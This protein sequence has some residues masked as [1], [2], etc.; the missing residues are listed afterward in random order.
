[1]RI[2]SKLTLSFLAFA[3][4]PLAVG[5]ALALHYQTQALTGQMR[6]QLESVAALQAQRLRELLAQNLERLALV[7]SRTQL[8][9]SLDRYV[10]NGDP[11]QRERL[12]RILRDARASIPS[13]E[14]I[15]VR[16][17]QGRVVAATDESLPGMSQGEEESFPL[18]SETGLGN[19]Y[20]SERGGK[21][22][23]RLAGPL[24]LE[25][26]KIG[27]VIVEGAADTIV[28]L[29]RD[30]TGL[31]DTGETV[32]VG[33]RRDG[34]PV[35]LTPL[36]FAPHAALKPIGR[37]GARTVCEAAL[38]ADGRAVFT[39]GVDYRGR[40]VLAAS[41]K[42]DPP[43]WALVV[44]KDRSEAFVPILKLRASVLVIIALTLVATLVAAPLLARSSTG[45]IRDLTRAAH[46]AVS[47][48]LSGR[49]KVQTHD[50]VGELALAFNNMMQSIESAREGLERKVEQRTTELRARNEDLAREIEER[51]KARREREK[52]L[53]EL[54]RS[55]RDLEQFAYV[56]S[57]DLQEPLR[58]VASFVD[59]LAKKYKGK[60]DGDADQYIGFAVNG[61]RRMQRLIRD[62]LSYSRVRTRGKPPEPVNA[63]KAL[64]LAIANLATTIQEAGAE[65]TYD[66]LPTVM[67]DQTQLGQL[68]QNLIG[69]ALKFRA[70]EPPH[71]HVTAQREGETWRF[72]V[73][74]NG[75]GIDPE[76]ADQVFVIFRRL[77]GR[78]EYK[79]TGIG[80][81]VCKSIVERHGGR[82]W[83]ESAPGEGA[84]F[85]FTL[86]ALGGETDGKGAG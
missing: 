85:H 21:L 42:I 53:A 58:M 6:A 61:A 82:I 43:G 45:P 28:S 8:R 37:E 2:N 26:K 62:L 23:I 24:Q 51:K 22:K 7:S 46:R 59:L 68:F 50:E 69:N 86:P 70:D 71:I 9:I 4:A 39:K 20:T 29:T 72:S 67:A 14:N 54:E 17:T 44:K 38:G 15:C 48:D 3:L 75:I 11:A 35:F 36:R 41:E 55:N 27:V 73:R 49:A 80:L 63:E 78:E 65:V 60:L 66:R 31:G 52:T 32:L 76:L 1:V 12:S 74:D 64:E 25:G 47:G 16:D 77:H 56:A 13:F 33:R 30:G 81:A 84:T 83:V 5:G 79:G 40:P 10:K 19:L 57:H 18:G 34:Q